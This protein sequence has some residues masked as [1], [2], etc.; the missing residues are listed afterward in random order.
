[1]AVSVTWRIPWCALYHSSQL[2]EI[3]SLEEAGNCLSFTNCFLQC[4]L[5]CLSTLNLQY[6]TMNFNCHP[7]IP[8]TENSS[9]MLDIEIQMVLPIIFVVQ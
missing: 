3:R 5:V 7:G 2:G 1:M 4:A 8:R 9:L 6:K